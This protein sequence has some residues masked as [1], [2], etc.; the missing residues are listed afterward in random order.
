MYFFLLR[1]RQFL[2]TNLQC[3]WFGLKV[4]TSDFLDPRYC[5]PAVTLGHRIID[6]RCKQHYDAG[7]TI[8]SFRY[9]FIG[10]CLEYSVV[11]DFGEILTSESVS[12]K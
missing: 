12:E 7:S 5:G 6:H 1:N 4:K 9:C 10:Y 11:S 3:V 8:T 2:Q